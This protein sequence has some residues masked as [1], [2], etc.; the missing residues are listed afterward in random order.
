MRWLG[1]LLAYEPRVVSPRELVPHLGLASA[2]EAIELF[3]HHYPH[4]V[5]KPTA[6][7][8]LDARFTESP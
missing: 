5:L 1:A 2:E 4:E 7:R 6:R 8:W 3:E